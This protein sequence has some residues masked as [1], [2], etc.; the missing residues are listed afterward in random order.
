MNIEQLNELKNERKMT[1]KQISNLLGVSKTTLFRIFHKN[2]LKSE[3]FSSWNSGKTCFDDDRILSGE[4]HPRWKNKSKYYI[5]FRLLVRQMK[6]LNLPC[7]ICHKQ[8]E[9]LHHT[10]KDKSNNEP[11]NLMPMC[12]SCHTALHNSEK[13]KAIYNH[14]CDFCN[15]NFTVFSH[16]NC[17]QKF[18]SLSCAAKFNYH[19]K[20]TTLQGNRIGVSMVN[21]Y[22]LFC[23]K[24]YAVM[25]SRKNSMFCS[26]SCSSRYYHLKKKQSF[27]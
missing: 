15:K 19:V 24:N 16:K 8:A 1:F 21:K 11:K 12:S 26:Y 22:C 20:K 13:G 27:H 14:N 2:G 10:D 5:E 17:K 3:R 9:L 18:C 7:E 23:K 6:E 25:A 4:K